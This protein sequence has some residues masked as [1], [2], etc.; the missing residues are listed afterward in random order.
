M[1]QLDVCPSLNVLREHIEL[2][3]CVP[4]RFAFQ[5][6]SSLVTNRAGKL[7]FFFRLDLLFK[8]VQAWTRIELGH[9]VRARFALQGIQAWNQMELGP[10]VPAR[11]AFQVRS[12][13]YTNRAGTQCPSSLCS[14]SM[15]KL[16]RKSSW[17]IV[18]PARCAFQVRSGSDPNQAGTQYPNSI[19]FHA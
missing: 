8:Y 2:G 5:V 7:C 6:R 3:H 15:F 11:F 18:F 16:G 9:S 19:W 13:V 14:P 4:A 10:W 12:S 1:C 17:D